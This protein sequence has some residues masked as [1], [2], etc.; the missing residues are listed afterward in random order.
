MYSSTTVKLPETFLGADRNF[1]LGYSFHGDIRLGFW[2]GDDYDRD[3]LEEP[4]SLRVFSMY[5]GSEVE[6]IAAAI[7]FY[8]RI[9]VSE[10]ETAYTFSNAAHEILV[11]PD[12]KE[13]R[14]PPTLT[15]KLRTAEGAPKSRFDKPLLGWSRLTNEIMCQPGV[16]EEVG[17]TAIYTRQDIF[18]QDTMLLESIPSSLE[19]SLRTLNGNPPAVDNRVAELAP[20]DIPIVAETICRLT[21]GEYRRDVYDLLTETFKS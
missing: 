4:K 17:A 16:T 1:R 18:G 15:W 5:H 6:L 19:T 3:A 10:S 9:G 11:D 14:R 2:V 8:R 20:A 13:F 21:M 12:M 7:G